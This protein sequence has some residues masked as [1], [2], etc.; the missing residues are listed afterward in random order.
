VIAR[1][2]YIDE[3]FRDALGKGFE[4]IVIF[5]AGFDSR[6]LR[7][8]HIIESTRIFELDAR[9]TQQEKLKALKKK[10]TMIPDALVFVP[11][12]FNKE[13]LDEK[14][15]EAGFEKNRKTLFL[16]EGVTM[17]LSDAAMDS[18]FSFVRDVSDAGSLIVFDYLYAGVLRQENRYY[19]E[20]DIF[21]TV[22]KAGEA[23]TFALEEGEIGSFLQRYGFILKSHNNAHDLEKEYFRNQEG[24]TV[25]KING[26]HCI[27]TAI[28]R[29]PQ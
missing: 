17:Y 8:N 27:V 13:Q 6:A 19:G 22:S 7:F 28:K 14:L 18:T 4:Q 23:W 5:G 20:K 24:K 21:K 11:I 10:K 9:I 2:K 12:D 1:T 26:T 15:F 29:V 16:L 3:A 25:G